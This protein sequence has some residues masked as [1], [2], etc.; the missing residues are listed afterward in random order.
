MP[1]WEGVQGHCWSLSGSDGH[2]EV[3]KG[4]PG[5]QRGFAREEPLQPLQL[6]GQMSPAAAI[7]VGAGLS[8]IL[9]PKSEWLRQPR[10]LSLTFACSS[11]S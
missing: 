10:A 5:S 3:T 7:G 4:H 8:H 2:R 6:P 1:G 9:V 11:G